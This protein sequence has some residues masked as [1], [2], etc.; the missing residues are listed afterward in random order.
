M[1]GDDG[2]SDVP[3]L[4][5]DLHAW[6]QGDRSKS[7]LGT[8]LLIAIVFLA[9]VAVW[10]CGMLTRFSVSGG[11]SG[12][13]LFELMCD[14]EGGGCGRVLQSRWATL[15]RSGI[16]I[17]AVGMGYFGM[18][19]VW[20]LVVGRCNRAGRFW[21][22]APLLI[23]LMGLFYSGL[24]VW[25]MWAQVG[26]YCGWCLVTHGLNVL[27]FVLGMMLWPR[28]GSA[29][30][31]PA[32]PS[33]RLGVAGVLLMASVWIVSPLVVYV[34]RLRGTV[35]VAVEYAN[36]YR[37]DADLMRYKYDRQERIDI[38]IRSDDPIRGV[39]DAKHTI[40][41]FSDFE[42][43][44][45]RK[46][47]D[48][49]DGELLPA[50]G[51]DL[52]VVF[53]H[54]PLNSDCNAGIEWTRHSTACVAAYWAEAA[55]E[56]GGVEG[57][58]K[59]HDLLFAVQNDLSGVSWA[60]L[61]DSVGLDGT[62]LGDVVSKRGPRNRIDEDVSLAE[63]LEVRGTPTVFVDGKRFGEWERIENWRAVLEP[64]GLRSND[65][66]TDVDPKPGE[67]PGP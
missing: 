10:V 40:V 61:A 19:G 47:S 54:Y 23:H 31:E 1:S 18:L 22:L 52:R 51:E 37:H 44:Q 4:H 27:M 36:R 21:Q 41:V 58:W 42:C 28:S 13:P 7:H 56:L 17:S 30:W 59:M 11:K 5:S 48:F 45:C 9:V 65:P 50:Y 62:A 20:Y 63:R 32:R 3:I 39:V 33:I 2:Q 29:N 57:F 24:M 67:L 49:V 26:A 16:P 60:G 6:P 38:P 64:A 8:V 53:K 66:R 43:S 55:R 15:G 12:S 14:P 35:V 46:F 34:K 25:V